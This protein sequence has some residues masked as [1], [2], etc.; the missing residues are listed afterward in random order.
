M[1]KF[2]HRI[3][4]ILLILIV[5]LADIS[6]MKYCFDM[7][8]ARRQSSLL[9]S[10]TINESAVSNVQDDAAPSP[11]KTE[12]ILQLEELQKQNPDIVAWIEIEGTEINYPVLQG[13]DNDFYM[14][15]DYN[16]NYSAGRFYFFG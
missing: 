15:R 12:R 7:Y 16:K 14:N 4:Y 3:I 1:D 9:D 11:Q 5:I 2:Y 8:S 10:V 13:Q 6:I